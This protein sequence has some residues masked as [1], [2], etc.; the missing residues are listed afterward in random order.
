LGVSSSDLEEKVIHYIM[1][2]LI[3]L[4]LLQ[5]LSILK[6]SLMSSSALTNGLGPFLKVKV[7]TFVKVKDENISNLLY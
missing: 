6:A 5:G 3:P 2:Y 7:E 1:V 4:V